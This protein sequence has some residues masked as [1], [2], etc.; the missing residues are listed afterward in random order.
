MERK[1]MVWIGITAAVLLVVLWW[2]FAPREDTRLRAT[3]TAEAT[4]VDVTAKVPGYV[5]DLQR[6]PG[7]EI[8]A[9]DVVCRI[10]RNDLTAQ[11]LAAEAGL[12]AA[13][14]RLADI[15]AGARSEE[16]RAAQAEVASAQARAEQA[17]SDRARYAA[18]YEADAIA[19]QQYEAAR[20]QAEV[21]RQQLSVAQEQLTLLTSGA[22]SQQ[23][24]AQR[25]EVE[26]LQAQLDAQRSLAEETQIISPAAGVVLSRNFE[27]NE[28]VPAGVPI[29][30]IGDLTHP[31]V[32]VYVSSEDLSR[33][34]LGGE[35][36]V[37]VDAEPNR[38]LRGHI[39]EIGQ[40]AEF[41]PRQ[42]ITARE[43]ANLVFAVKI[44]IDDPEG[45]VKPGMPADVVWP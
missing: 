26:R 19:A 22:R 24:A 42:S 29:I 4:M 33:V 36:K 14:A 32:R 27:N 40:R 37:Y 6:E 35:T 17:E 25:S 34:T 21:A 3:G 5:R 30:T 15:E 44:R 39:E 13:R 8:Q 31:Y 7:T 9:G 18:L 38:P 45:I 2:Q 12:A 20:T 16:L 28:F 23:V 41:T 43:R 10:E 1:R 11:V